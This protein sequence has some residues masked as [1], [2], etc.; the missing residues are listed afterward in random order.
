MLHCTIGD[1]TSLLEWVRGDDAA[2]DLIT[3]EWHEHDHRAKHAEHLFDVLDAWITDKQRDEIVERAQLLRQPY[4]AVRYPGE[5]FNDEQLLA[6]G[7]FVEV[8]HPE[9]G[10]IIRYP[11]A[12]YLMH[13]TPWRVYRRPPLVGEHNDAILRD[14]LGI[15]GE[16]LAVLVAEVVI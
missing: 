6:R 1:W 10:R 5:L 8:E 3:P 13:G 12:P 4:A 11:G 9:L 16:E 15:S 2:Q 14:E 7:Y